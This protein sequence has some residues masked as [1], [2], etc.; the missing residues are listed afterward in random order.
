MID[1]NLC[2]ETRT[3]ANG[4]VH[5]SPAMQGIQSGGTASQPLSFCFFFCIFHRFS[6]PE[7]ASLPVGHFLSALALCLICRLS[8]FGI[9][10]GFVGA[11][12]DLA[13]SFRCQRCNWKTCLPDRRRRVV[14]FAVFL[15][16]FPDRDRRPLYFS[17][18][19]IALPLSGKLIFNPQH[20]S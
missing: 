8:L 12:T 14:V 13:K 4:L 2:E 7:K 19:L 18:W 9:I 20:P 10:S 15:L 6:Q 16:T 1:R 11:A 5:R 3:E 17:Q